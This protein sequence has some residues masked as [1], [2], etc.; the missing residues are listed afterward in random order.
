ME[1]NA[2]FDAAEA[3]AQRMKSYGKCLL[4]A[5]R[6]CALFMS[7]KSP[8][9]VIAQPPNPHTYTAAS[10]VP[11]QPRV[12]A[13][14]SKTRGVCARRARVV[15]ALPC[16]GAHRAGQESLGTREARTGEI[17]FDD[18]TSGDTDTDNYPGDTPA[19]VTMRPKPSR[20][21][22]HETSMY[23]NADTS[24]IAKAKNRRSNFSTHGST[25]RLATT[26]TRALRYSAAT[27][28]LR[29]VLRRSAA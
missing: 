23:S 24:R 7:A 25:S 4:C 3:S 16:P 9:D 6:V 15:L 1:Q 22:V 17:N 18:H 12:P 5:T 28:P 29:C 11:R 20:S 13:W 2:G 19:A 21:D 14:H 26:Q 27:P 8:K 10:V